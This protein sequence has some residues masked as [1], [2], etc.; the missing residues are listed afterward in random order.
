[1]IWQFIVDTILKHSFVLLRLIIYDILEN[2]YY[3]RRAALNAKIKS[4]AS[5][6]LHRQQTPNP[7]AQVPEAVPPN[8][9]QSDEL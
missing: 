7:D 9:E 2:M 1:M 4:Q 6:N 8:F 3:T 5:F